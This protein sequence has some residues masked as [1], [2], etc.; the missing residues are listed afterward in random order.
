MDW[1][2][3]TEILVLYH[4]YKREVPDRIDPEPRPCDAEPTERAVRYRIARGRGIRHNLKVHAPAG[5]RRHRLEGLGMDVVGAH[6]F[7]CAR[8]QQADAVEL[9]ALQ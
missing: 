7:H 6:H 4:P 2:R 3:G 5:A 8:R 1:P 9:A